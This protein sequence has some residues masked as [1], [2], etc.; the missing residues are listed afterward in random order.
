[1]VDLYLGGDRR[2]IVQAGR[3]DAFGSDR[4]GALERLQLMVEEIEGTDPGSVYAPLHWGDHTL[5]DEEAVFYE[6]VVM[7]GF[8]PGQ[9]IV[10]Q[11]G[12]YFGSPNWRAFCPYR[13]TWLQ[14]Q[15]T[16]VALT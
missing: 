3:L 16:R 5:K 10:F 4:A 11:D 9:G 7:T 15:P 14:M 1:V 6:H 2:Q 13:A 12:E 8:E